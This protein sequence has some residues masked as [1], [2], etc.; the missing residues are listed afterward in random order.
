MVGREAFRVMAR[1]YIVLAGCCFERKNKD[2]DCRG[3]DAKIC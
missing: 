1:Y 3:R 2:G